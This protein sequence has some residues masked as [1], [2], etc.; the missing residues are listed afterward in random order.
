MR[1][2]Y[3]NKQEKTHITQLIKQ[4]PEIPETIE[5][6]RERRKQLAEIM[7]EYP[8]KADEEDQPKQTHEEKRIYTCL[9]CRRTFSTIRGKLNHLKHNPKC[10]EVPQQETFISECEECNR[11]FSSPGQLGER[12]KFIFTQHMGEETEKADGDEEDTSIP[13]EDEREERERKE[14]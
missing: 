6:N 13:I 7:L 2:L 10:R 5:L 4:I 9:F 11:T 12:Q 14:I 3:V 8:T 1:K